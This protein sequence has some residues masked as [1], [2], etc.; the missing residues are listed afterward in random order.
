MSTTPDPFHEAADIGCGLFLTPEGC[1]ETEEGRYSG[2]PCADTLQELLE[3]AEIERNR[4]VA[5]IE[6]LVLDE[7]RAKIPSEKH[8]GY[9]MALYDLFVAIHEDA[10]TT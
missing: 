1:R 10:P 5:I 6:A 9:R 4:I 2:C 7:S 3:G 8:D